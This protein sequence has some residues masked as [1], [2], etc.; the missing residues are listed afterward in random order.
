MST[1]HLYWHYILSSKE[2]AAKLL[3]HFQ[4][5]TISG[6]SQNHNGALV[7]LQRTLGRI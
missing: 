6:Y 7:G 3:I 1:F 5:V 4:Y 2:S